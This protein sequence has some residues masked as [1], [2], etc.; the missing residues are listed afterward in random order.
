MNNNT[1][2]GPSVNRR[3]QGDQ[4]PMQYRSADQGRNNATLAAIVYVVVVVDTNVNT[5]VNIIV[6]G[7]AHRVEDDT[8]WPEGDR[9]PQTSLSRRST[10]SFPS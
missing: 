6:C 9:G 10:T 3:K 5:S 4:F 7:G 8:L 2:M 1:Y